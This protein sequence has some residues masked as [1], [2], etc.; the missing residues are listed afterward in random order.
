MNKRG[1]IKIGVIGMILSIIVISLMIIPNYISAGKV[2]QYY[3]GNLTCETFTEG[4]TWSAVS[5]KNTGPVTEYYNWTMDNEC[6][7]EK[8]CDIASIYSYARY[9]QIGTTDDSTTGNAYLLI[10]NKTE[11]QIPEHTRYVA[12]QNET[13]TAG[14]ALGPRWECG[15]GGSPTTC[16]T[17]GKGYDNSS[18]NYSVKVYAYSSGAA[19]KHVYITDVFNVKY[20]WCWTPIIYDATVSPESADY[21]QTF[22]FTINVT[23]PGATTTVYLW[24]RPVG[25]TWVQEGSSQTCVDCAQTKKTFTVSDFSAGDIG[26]REFKFNATD[27]TYST[28]AWASGTTN[29]CLDVGND[30][31]FTVTD[32]TVAEG[33]PV[34]ANEK[35][36]G[37]QSGATA[38]WGT[39]W[40]FAVDIS[41]PADGAGDI[42]LNFSVDTG[43]GFV[44]RETETCSEAQCSTPQTFTFYVDNFTCSD[45]SPTANAAQYK[46]TA[47][48]LNDTATTTQTFTIDKDNIQFIYEQGNNS[49]ANRS[50]EQ[51]TTFI[52]RVNDT[53]KAPS[54]AWVNGTNITFS[55]QRNSFDYHTDSNF[56]VL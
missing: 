34:L 53:D 16:D 18:V 4:T 19:G 15:I 48:N 7:G 31:V 51:T 27:G 23:N 41:N 56:V 14:S 32:V 24:T 40:T 26:N 45:I 11:S 8:D 49:I 46:F 54:G 50:G 36:N 12:Y 47:T 29:E 2:E 28:E 38:G 17:S 25:G 3:S 44:L 22:T 42:E 20:D 13:M 43:S 6:P 30:C 33:T 52:L 9:L 10:G 55:V 35:V 1:Y 5:T 21:E 37:V 39:N